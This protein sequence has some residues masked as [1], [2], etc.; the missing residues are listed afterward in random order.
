MKSLQ[1]L[2]CSFA[3]VLAAASMAHGQEATERY[4]PIGQSPGQSGKTTT[5]GTVQSVDPGSRSLTVAAHGTSVG[6]GWTERTR[7]WLDRSHQQQG[8]LKG[9]ASDIQVGRRI[10]VKPDPGDR[11]RADWIK[12]EPTAAPN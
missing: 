2:G 12:I 3:V 6:L 5:I 10:E 8:A 11:S 9:T 4:L 7:F 1:A